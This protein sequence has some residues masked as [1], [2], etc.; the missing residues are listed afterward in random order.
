MKK[1]VLLLLILFIVING[2][3][4]KGL[5]AQELTARET[6]DWNNYFSLNAGAGTNFFLVDGISAGFF[7]EPRYALSQKFTVGT[8][9]GIHFS[10]ENEGFNIIVLETQSFFRWNFIRRPYPA[11]ASGYTVDIFIQGGMGFLGAFR[12]EDVRD[13]RAS[14][15]FDATAGV[16]VPLSSNWHVELSISGGYP[17]YGGIAFTVGKKFPLPQRT[18]IVPSDTN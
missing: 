18:V 10:V 3:N 14:L 7:I 11:N 2:L 17:F 1:N 15:L 12:G 4:V 8:R 13:S 5:F 16:N 6:P 9:G